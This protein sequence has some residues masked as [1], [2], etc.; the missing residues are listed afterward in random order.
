MVMQ[1][2]EQFADRVAGLLGRGRH[3][4]TDQPGELLGRQVQLV[5]LDPEEIAN[6][7]EV[8]SRRTAL[9]AQVLVELSAVDR[10]LPAN[11]GDRAV[12]AAGQ[13]EVGGE[14]LTHV[15]N[16]GDANGAIVASTSINSEQPAKL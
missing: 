8:E 4:R 7:L 11:F 9:P 6:A 15:R 12:V 16:P 5:I 2:A 13:F 14:M 1:R 3:P 10:E